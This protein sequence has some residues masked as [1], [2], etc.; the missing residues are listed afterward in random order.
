MDLD[1]SERYRAMQKQDEVLEII[2]FF[3]IQAHRIT[4]DANSNFDSTNR[5][6]FYYI[7]NGRYLQTGPYEK[8]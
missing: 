8:K 6:I 7:R 2:L 4:N 3:E 5:C 1:L